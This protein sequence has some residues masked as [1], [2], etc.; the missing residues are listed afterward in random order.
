MKRLTLTLATLTLALGL[1][2]PSLALPLDIPHLTW[3]DSCATCG[4]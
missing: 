2:A 4:R 3:P 1:A